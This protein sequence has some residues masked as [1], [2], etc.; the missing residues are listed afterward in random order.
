LRTLFNYFISLNYIYL[1][2]K[3]MLCETY[4]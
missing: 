3:I 4:Y 2:S 1:S